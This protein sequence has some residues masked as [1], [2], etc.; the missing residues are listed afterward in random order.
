MKRS[1][2]MVVALALFSG[3]VGQAKAELTITFS[4]SGA[5]VVA[6]GTGSLN[7]TD[8][9]FNGFDTNHTSVNASQGLVLIGPTS[10]AA[11]YA[12]YYGSISGPTSFGLGGAFLASSGTSTGTNNHDAGVDGATGQLLVPGGYFAGRLFTVSATWDNTTISQLGLTPGTYTWTW[13]S[14]ANADGL[15]VVVPGVV[16]V[17]EPGSLTVVGTVGALCGL[18]FAWRRRK[19]TA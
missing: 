19:Q 4:Q 17:P 10:S 5:N 18:G 16:P 7:F 11:D 3:A 13:G 14:G 1:M 9:T 15:E 12:D 2:L 6:N 8:L